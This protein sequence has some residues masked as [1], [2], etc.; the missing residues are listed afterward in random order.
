MAVL[1]DGVVLGVE[2]V[3]AAG[4]VPLGVLP[5]VLLAEGIA[6]EAAAFGPTP[7][8][9]LAW[10]GGGTLRPGGSGTLL[11]TGTLFGTA[12]TLP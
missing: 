4:V 5:A 11:C 1:D 10:P 12:G 8:A 3:L 6:A 2:A 9:A 7:G